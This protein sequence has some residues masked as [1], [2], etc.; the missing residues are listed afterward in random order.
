MQ[1]QSR[2]GGGGRFQREPRQFIET[3]R[4][5]Y[6][7]SRDD[8]GDW[9]LWCICLSVIAIFLLIAVFVS[10]GFSWDNRRDYYALNSQLSSLKSAYIG[11]SVDGVQLNDHVWRMDSRA[12]VDVSGKP[13][14]LQGFAFLHYSPGY[15]PAKRSVAAGNISLLDASASQPCYTFLSEGTRWQRSPRWVLDSTNRFGLTDG[16]VAGEISAAIRTWSDAI[17]RPILGV[18][19]TTIRADGPDI[20]TPDGKNEI[21]FGKINTEGVIAITFT[22]GQFDGPLAKRM[23]F[24]F[25]LVFNDA[26]FCWGNVTENPRCMD[27]RNIATHEIGHAL[28]L[29]DLTATRCSDHC[30]YGTSAHGET[31]KTRLQSGDI[32]GITKLYARS[33]TAAN[34]SPSPPVRSPHSNPVYGPSGACI[35]SS[36]LYLC[37]L[38][39]FY[40][41]ITV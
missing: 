35:I 26:D 4:V 14:M 2:G 21:S 5:V 37:L 29:G 33:R 9:W 24:E 28:G 11:V 39:C 10:F 19:D 12:T 6:V 17:G 20:Y 22:W 15:E 1:K 25:D 18:R 13:T 16:F 41:L 40:L 31:S 34:N 32:D 3:R 7:K 38:C 36:T 27:L 30:M 23:I 8:G